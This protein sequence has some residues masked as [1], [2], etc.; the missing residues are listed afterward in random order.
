MAPSVFLN[1][2]KSPRGQELARALGKSQI[3]WDD[4]K[5]NVISEYEPVTESWGFAG[6]K[7]GWALALKQKKRS[8]LYLVPGDHAFVC[9]FALSENAV[10]QAQAS[11]L[12]AGVLKIVNEAPRYPEGRGVRIEVKHSADVT[13][14]KKLVSIKMAC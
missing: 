5:A 1:K 6:K 3:L 2:A 12:P 4:I 10:T 7:Y 14:V 13:L 8:I 9:S 11:S